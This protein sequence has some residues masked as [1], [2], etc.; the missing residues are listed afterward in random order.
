MQK[1]WQ[2][3]HEVMTNFFENS[4]LAQE[5]D[6]LPR[7]YG[8]RLMYQVECHTIQLIGREKGITITEIARKMNK[9]VSASSQVVRKLREKELVTTTRNPENQREI[10]LQLTPAGREVFEFHEK[11]DEDS[12][13]NIFE[14]FKE[15]STADL[16]LFSNMLTQLRTPL[17]DDLV[18]S[19]NAQATETE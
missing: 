11:Y 16:A 2:L 9:T 18:H 19:R 4:R 5:Y 12:Y 17:H 10:I 15:F 7:M 13:R 3:F 8:T 14:Y 1:K 6:S